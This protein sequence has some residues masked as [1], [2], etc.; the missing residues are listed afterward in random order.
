MFIS[1]VRVSFP[2]GKQPFPQQ[3]GVMQKV[4]S[5]ATHCQ[6]AL[7]ES[8]TGTGKTLSLLCSSL[9]WQRKQFESDT[10]AYL[11][12]VGPSSQQAP[13]TPSS[14]PVAAA[15][16]TVSDLKKKS[17][18]FTEEDEDVFE[19]EGAAFCALDESTPSNA[20][21][22]AA[23]ALPPVPPKPVK[24][25][26][27]SRTH[28]QLLQV[29]AELK[30]CPATLLA[31]PSGAGGLK[32]TVLGSR[33]QYCVNPKVQKD[34]T[35]NRN[36]ACNTLLKENKCPYFAASSLLAKQIGNQIMDLEDLVTRGKKEISCPF[37]AAKRSMADAHI[38]FLPYNYL[39]D[40]SIRAGLADQ[41]KGSV[42]IFD[43]AH[44]VEDV[45]RDAASIEM[46]LDAMQTTIH[47]LA[48]IGGEALELGKACDEL[49]HLLG[50]L[51]AW[52]HNRV[53]ATSDNGLAADNSV[54][55]EGQVAIAS[56]LLQESI[57]ITPHTLLEYRAYLQL[58]KS[59]DDKDESSQEP[60]PAAGAKRKP[61]TLSNGLVGQID[62]LLYCLEFLVA[63]EGR[64]S[65]DF[66]VAMITKWQS[67]GT[68]YKSGGKHD[69]F[70]CIWCLNP[71]VA[72]RALAE[73]TRSLILTSGTLSPLRA[74]AAE[75]GVEFKHTLEANHVCDINKQ[76]VALGVQRM[77]NELLDCTFKNA[78]RLD[79][80][81]AIGDAVHLVATST[82][83]GVLVFFP[84][85]AMLERCSNRWKQTG[86]W[87]ALERVKP[88]SI[89]TKGSSEEFDRAVV[90]YRALCAQQSGGLF[91]AVFRGKLSEG[92][93]FRDEQARAVVI[94]GI[95]FP[96]TRDLVV[97][98]KK[99]H[100]DQAKR[101]AVGLPV[102]PLSGNEWYEQ[103]A[104]RA[105]NQALGRVI[106]HRHDYGAI[107]LLDHRFREP[108]V[109]D[110]LSKWMRGAVRV[111]PELCE[112]PEM[113]TEFF[114][115][116]SVTPHLAPLSRTN[117]ATTTPVLPPRLSVLPSSAAI[118]AIRRAATN[119]ATV[120]LTEL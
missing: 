27:S 100:Q 65:R 84:S 8:P 38:V 26:Y 118:Q 99:Q 102:Q 44:N 49:S 104:Y 73:S 89:E 31:G 1:G 59:K 83:G 79:F 54:V 61:T 14:L 90:Q 88:I 32:I 51:A 95:P 97:G 108:R 28:T 46:S 115:R 62:S 45:S 67:G 66:R 64:Y 69:K 103:Q 11:A 56:I 77:N 120:D 25:F 16:P 75:L 41:I 22:A 72:F 81:S 60:S 18:F 80:Q 17:R 36:D 93:D 113:M 43:E 85:Y 98:L 24:I 47:Q 48:A 119:S 13:F 92:I 76:L 117:V 58:L 112:V 35:T 57:S 30:R 106:R 78:E 96:N 105:L 4:I 91:F 5:S 7:L 37:F 116:L 19:Q 63:D 109:V 74:F 86:L 68:A 87:D 114:Y 107:V 52:A 82:P 23:A 10:Q 50:G 39:M 12:L 111:T 33:E 29:V 101:R 3:I 110:N 34:K 71:A 21:A 15:V 2:E 9:S 6:N 42:V 94:V 55:L 40:P 53:A 20:P 70:L